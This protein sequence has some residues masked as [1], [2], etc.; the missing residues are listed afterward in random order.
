MRA[1][2]WPDEIMHSSKTLISSACDHCATAC[3][4]GAIAS[5]G[6]CANREVLFPGCCATRQRCAADP[7]SIVSAR[8]YMGPG[9]SHR[10][11]SC[12]AAALSPG[13]WAGEVNGRC[14]PSPLVGEG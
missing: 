4:L 3:A 12:R 7:G 14:V 13:T 2:P 9:F 10:V 5:P 11:T 6:C 1:E 8:R